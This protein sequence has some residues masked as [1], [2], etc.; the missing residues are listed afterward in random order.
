MSLFKKLFNNNLS[1]FYEYD[2]YK[3]KRKKKEKKTG[4]FS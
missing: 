3:A 4:L 2:G 1:L